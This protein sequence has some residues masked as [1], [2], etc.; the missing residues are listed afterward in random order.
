MKEL[1][2]L[3][4]NDMVNF[5][6]YLH[7]NVIVLIFNLSGRTKFLFCCCPKTAKKSLLITMFLSS[8]PASL[9]ALVILNKR[10]AVSNQI[11]FL[12]S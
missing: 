6:M 10:N 12:W 2:Y 3:F 4:H 7:S 11:F 5:R 1:Y 8:P 9:F